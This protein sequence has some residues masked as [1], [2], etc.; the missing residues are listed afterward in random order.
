[1]LLF[2]GQ[3]DKWEKKVAKIFQ[4]CHATIAAL[5]KADMAELPLRMYLLGVL[6]LDKIP[7]NDQETMAYEFMSQAF[8]LYEDEISDSRAQMAAISLMIGTLEQTTCFS[9]E[10]HDPL[11]TQCALA[12][13]KLLKKPDQ[14][15][16]VMVCSHLFWTGKT[17]TNGGKELNDAKRV[18]D[19]LKKGVKI[20]SQ[21]MDLGTKVQ[22]LVELLNKYIFFL[23][24]G[25]ASVQIEMIQEL[26]DRIKEDSPNLE[27]NDEGEQI[28]SHFANTLAHIKTRMAEEEGPSYKDLKL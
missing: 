1:L 27:A 2:L 21:V 17:K 7:Y 8:S 23:E 14:C 11:R 20:A 25:V 10:N 9:E 12:A 24:K 5:V 6:A 19:C 15:R 4:F 16:G 13:S 22:L 28:G 18:L 26:I 3:D